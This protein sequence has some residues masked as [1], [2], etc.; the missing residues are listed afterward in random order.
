MDMAKDVLEPQNLQNL[1]NAQN[2]QNPQSQSGKPLMAGLPLPYSNKDLN[3]SL[4]MP[5]LGFFFIRW[6]AAPWLGAADH[7]GIGVTLFTLCF[8]AL[9]GCWFS[10]GRELLRPAPGV[11]LILILLAGVYFSLYENS[12]LQGAALAFLMV[13]A[14]YFV[15]VLGE[16]RIEKKLGSYLFWDMLTALA[17]LPFGQAGGLLTFP[18]Q[19]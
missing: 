16:S 4:I 7:M 1:Q 18:R 9:L 2:P 3:F 8:I 10:P 13:T 19:R 14:A 15:L 12:L 6:I 11:Y 17:R 5:F